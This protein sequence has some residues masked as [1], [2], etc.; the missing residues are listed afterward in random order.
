[1]V[2]AQNVADF[3]SGDAL[4][5]N[6]RDVGDKKEAYSGRGDAIRSAD[7]AGIEPIEQGSIGD[8]ELRINP[9]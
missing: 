9:S 6:R 8:G 3:V 4:I 2:Q 5:E 7:A 1:M